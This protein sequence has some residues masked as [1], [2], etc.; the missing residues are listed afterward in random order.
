[1]ST[2]SA[3]PLR[4]QAAP[5]LFQLLA[6]SALSR[7]ALNACGIPIAILEAGAGHAVSQVNAAFSACFGLREGEAA[8]HSLGMLLL[9]GDE[10]PVQ[11]MLADPSR[12][13]T[14]NTWR[15]DGTRL[16]VEAT[17]G[18]VHDADGRLTHWVVTLSD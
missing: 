1:M 6:D 18:R 5:A 12:F 17:V 8:G 3:K 2:G 4:P 13:W 9:Q 11:R 7:A 14:L 15:R 10:K 16:P